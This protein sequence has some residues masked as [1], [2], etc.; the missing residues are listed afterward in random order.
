MKLNTLRAKVEH[1]T[2]TFDRMIG[3]Y[4]VFFKKKQG[5]FEGIKETVKPGDGYAED[6]RYMG[7]T[8]VATTVEAKLA[9]FKII[10]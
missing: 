4:A 1:G 8:K 6:A 2:S 3:D 9:W 10:N 5:V 7:T